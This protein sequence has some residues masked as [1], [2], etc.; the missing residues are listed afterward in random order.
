MAGTVTGR[1]S[2]V[3]LSAHSAGGATDFTSRTHSTW[4]MGDFSLTL[5]RGTIEQDLIGERGNYFD[6]GALSLEGSLTAAKFATSGLSDILDNLLDDDSKNY[7]YLAISGTVSTDTDATYI[8][9]YLKSCQVTGYDISIGDA[10]TITEASIDF[11]HMLP[12]N[13][14]YNG[15]CIMDCE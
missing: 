12:Q 14:T 7:Q 15:G 6:Q 4:G 3:Y 10:D 9:W 5:S 2:K 1:N 13:I 8:S 11:V